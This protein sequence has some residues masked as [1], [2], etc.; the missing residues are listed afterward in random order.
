MRDGAPEPTIGRLATYVRCLRAA[1]GE[2]IEMVS[3]AG[4]EERTGV[5]SAQ[6]RKD[7]SY[8]GEFGKPGLG[9][10]VEPLL[11][12]LTHI[13]GL[14]KERTVVIVGAGNLGAALVGYPGFAAAGF[15][16][17]G[18]F[19]NNY[20]KIGRRVWDLEIQ[21][22]Y[23]L[24]EVNKRLQADM[25]LITTPAEAAQ[26]VA[27]IMAQAGIKG[28]LNFTPGRVSSPPGVV[29][30]NVDLTRE[31]E[32]LSFFLTRVTERT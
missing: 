22:V 30:R 23:T 16:R 29:L 7:L 14:D 26:E 28:I 24:P 1:L 10:A 17:V 9:Y 3:S 19:D 20:A 21:D 8:F 2:G 12:R 25:G 13:M 27:D 6:V 31:L 4:I 11:T 15:R 32:V 5:S 18:I